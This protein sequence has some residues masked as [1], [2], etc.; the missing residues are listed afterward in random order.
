MLT[1]GHPKLS[2]RYCAWLKNP[3]G[4]TPTERSLFGV[5]VDGKVFIVRFV[6]QEEG[7]CVGQ[8]RIYGKRDELDSSG[9]G[10]KSCLTF[11]HT[12]RHHLTLV[13]SALATKNKLNLRNLFQY[14]SYEEYVTLDRLQDGG[15]WYSEEEKQSR[16]IW[17][18]HY[19]QCPNFSSRQGTNGCAGNRATQDC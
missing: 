3:K 10:S 13:V 18:M 2:N 11:I 6:F 15:G 9:R 12:P 19:F 16:S 17:V 8:Q 5:G 1:S 7:K 4:L 14:Y